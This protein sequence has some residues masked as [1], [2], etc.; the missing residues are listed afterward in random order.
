LS[1][2][3]LPF[4]ERNVEIYLHGTLLDNE[5]EAADLYVYRLAEKKALQIGKVTRMLKEISVDC[6]LNIGQNNYTV[7]KMLE[8]AQNQNIEIN[9]SSNKI[10][11]YKIGD[12]PFTD[13]CDYM[14]NCSYVCSPDAKIEE[15]DIIRDTYTDSFV[16][17]NQPRIIGRILEL[18]REQNVYT[19]N[20][21]INSINIVKQYPIEQIFSALTYLIEN[22]N[23]Y[24]IDK[25][26]RLGNLV[27]KDM[28]YLFQPIEITDENITMYERNAPIDYKRKSFLLEYSSDVVQEEPEKEKKIAEI[29]EPE[30]G[31]QQPIEK[32][33]E[34]KTFE[35][36]MKEINE[37]LDFVYNTKK[38][39]KGEKN[40]YK[41][42]AFVIKILIDEYGFTDDSIREY[43][44]EHILDMLLFQDKMILIKHYY[45]ENNAPNGI[46]EV[47][48]KKYLDERIVRSNEYW[49]IV[50]MK[51]D[52]LRIY[53]KNENNEFVEVDSDDYQLFV[54]DLLRF[55]VKKN[56]LNNTVGFVN[57]FV[58]KKSNQKEMVFKIKDLTQKRNNTGARAD[59]AGKVKIIKILNTIL[60][61]PKY[62]DENTEKITQIGLCAI[63]EFIMR[64]LNIV[65]KKG[66]VFFL[67]PEQTAIT[68]IVKFSF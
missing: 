62:N 7:E 68:Q 56:T 53:T 52:I 64:R 54:K 12:K 21:L 26:G 42:A 1:H 17:M 29:R 49:G 38:L 40:W 50:L 20:Q 4:E 44:I 41:H 51:D 27:N 61:E 22:K 10:I 59:D 16:K 6:I 35:N 9:L 15:N 57:L 46:N 14:D 2:C 47:L 58:S 43:M 37:L 8:I 19:R 34:M 63:L 31:S 23:E 25:Y 32:K 28:Y 11:P 36:L 60:E 18:Y 66:K 67:N 39:A 55:D 5:D 65:N 33:K 48:I 13:I 45:V 24:L 30:K 3:R